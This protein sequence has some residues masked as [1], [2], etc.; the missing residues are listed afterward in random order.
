V[1]TARAANL[2]GAVALGIGDEIR[3]ATERHAAEG[4]MAPAAIVFIGHAPGLA[5]EQLRYAVGLS[6]P[7]TVRLVDRLAAQGLLA[8]RVSAADARAVALH[9]TAKGCRERER[10]LA[11][12]HGSIHAALQALSAQERRRLEGLLAKLLANLLRDASHACAI[13][14][15]C[16][17]RTCSACPVEAELRVRTA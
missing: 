1:S 9:L 17:E 11:E 16:D 14:R 5:I 12:R 2:L 15:L 7:G 6:H 13:C 8:R 3:A 4:G 10:I